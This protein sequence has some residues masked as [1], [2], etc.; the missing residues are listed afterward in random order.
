M[1]RKYV[2]KKYVV[3]KYDI[4]MN[5]GDHTFIVFSKRMMMIM[6]IYHPTSK[7][8]LTISLIVLTSL[9]V[10]QPLAVSITYGQT[11]STNMTSQST[12]S[13]TPE[14]V[15][16]E[17]QKV[18]ESDNPVDIATFAYVWGFP[19]ITNMRTIDESTDPQHFSDSEA[20]GP[21][22]EF[23]YRTKLANANFTQ[24]CETQCRYSVQ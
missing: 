4:Y 5:K 6:K 16:A 2:V 13:I 3:K 11:N 20:N 17:M 19:L 1:C 7:M 12:E 8:I 21:W 10:F 22:N 14:S 23:H 24:F 18:S 9:M 15:K